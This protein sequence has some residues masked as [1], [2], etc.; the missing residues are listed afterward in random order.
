MSSHKLIWLNFRKW[1][2]YSWS[3]CGICVFIF[4][5]GLH[6]WHCC[7][8]IGLLRRQWYCCHGFC[9]LSWSKLCRL[10]NISVLIRA[11]WVCAGPSASLLMR[12]MRQK[13]CDVVSWIKSQSAW[14]FSL[15]LVLLCFPTG[16]PWWK[17]LPSRGAH[18]KRTGYLANNQWGQAFLLTGQWVW[19]CTPRGSG[20][21]LQPVLT[22]CFWLLRRTGSK[23]L[24]RSLLGS[25]LSVK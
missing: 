5:M 8:S 25:W 14:E 9:I 20:R 7:N 12:I 1:Q 6:T 3:H 24:V 16:A 21:R 19:K 2:T 17:K 23:D 4:S 13:W 18:V 15:W 22:P 10:S 11:P